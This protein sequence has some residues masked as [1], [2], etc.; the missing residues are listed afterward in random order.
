[1]HFHL[2]QC[3]TAAG[4][5][6]KIPPFVWKSV[7]KLES[8]QEYLET[9][10]LYRVPGD[11]A[12]VQK[13]RVEVDQVC[14]CF[15]NFHRTRLFPEQMGSV[16]KLHR[17]L[18]NCRGAKTLSTRTSRTPSS[19]QAAQVLI[20]WYWQLS[21]QH[22]PLFGCLSVPHGDISIL[23]HASALCVLCSVLFPPGC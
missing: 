13:I 23:R 21:V 12:K 14:Q 11:A 2:L 3:R 10:G 17:C 6:V 9:D 18:N 16:W 5:I 20:I 4:K 15:L 22:L 1:M 7:K 19:I 8:E